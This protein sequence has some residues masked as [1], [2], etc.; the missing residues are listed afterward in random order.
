MSEQEQQQAVFSIEKIFVKDLSVEVPNAPAIYME[1]EA[2]KIDVQMNTQA[3][4]VTDNVFQVL[5]TV[6][7][8]AKIQDRTMFLVEATQG[9]LFRIAGLPQEQIE[10]ALGI[11]CPNV[12]FPYMRETVSEAVGRAGFMPLYLNP[13]NFEA[14]FAQRMAQAQA[15]AQ[16]AGQ[17]N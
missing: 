7:V 4:A 3:G 13:V 15:E 12:L 11:A 10:L 9:G 2:P 14:L 16:Q 17:P 8:S 6:T 5:L 1:R